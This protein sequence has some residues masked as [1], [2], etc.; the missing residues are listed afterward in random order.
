M[1][2]NPYI[3]LGIGS[4]F[5]LL[6]GTV[7]TLGWAR[8]RRARRAIADSTGIE[9]LRL[10]NLA[11]G[12]PYANL[13]TRVISL[14]AN[15]FTDTDGNI[16]DLANF[17]AYIAQGSSA[18]YPQIKSGDLL[19]FDIGTTTLRYAFEIPNLKEYR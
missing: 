4:F 17:D 10:F 9:E 16:L 14:S 1:S 18:T 13:R 15:R 2:I 7:I 3:L 12:Y 5:A 11:T 6:Y 8:T 19:L